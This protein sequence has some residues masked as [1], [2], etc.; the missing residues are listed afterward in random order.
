M[1]VAAERLLDSSDLTPPASTTVTPDDSGAWQAA[2]W[3]LAAT[4]AA[5]VLSYAFQI[6]VA[7]FM[8]PTSYSDTV[9]MLS[10]YMVCSLPLTPIFLLITRRVV[11]ARA[12]QLLRLRVRDD[13]LP[14]LPAQRFA[15]LDR[16]GYEAR[17]RQRPD[18][19][20]V[21]HIRHGPGRAIRAQEAFHGSRAHMKVRHVRHHHVDDPDATAGGNRERRLRATDPA[22]REQHY[23]GNPDRL[24]PRIRSVRRGSGP[25]PRPSRGFDDRQSSQ[26]L[27]ALLT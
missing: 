23:H 19:R 10:L 3:G 13:P 22:A 1:A 16:H 9:A 12:R 11:E 18:E 20:L 27:H 21:D 24:Q 14:L 17:V 25:C 26:L 5:A 7:R 6:L 4:I 8:S 2:G 15:R